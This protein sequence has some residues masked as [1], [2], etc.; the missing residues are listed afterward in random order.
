MAVVGMVVVD[1]P[2]VVVLVVASV[3]SFPEHAARSPSESAH[4]AA[5]RLVPTCISTTRPA[6]CARGR[7]P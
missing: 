1:A 5:R 7:G 4:A 3:V 2:V 6:A